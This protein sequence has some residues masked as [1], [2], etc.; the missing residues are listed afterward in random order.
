MNNMKKTLERSS[1][2]SSS[3]DLITHKHGALLCLSAFIEASPHTV[4]NYVPALLIYLG[5]FL[6]DAQPIPGMRGIGYMNFFKIR[7][8]K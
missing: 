4:P 3:P 7:K 8:S 1:K 6:H 2:K 5:T